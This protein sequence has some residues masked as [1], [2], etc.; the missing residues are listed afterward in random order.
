MRKNPYVIVIGI[1]GLVIL[2]VMALFKIIT[3]RQVAATGAGL[4]F[5]LM[6]LGVVFF[7]NRHKVPT[8]LLWYFFL[9]QFW[10]LFAVPIFL[11]RIMNWGVSFDQLSILGIPGPV[12]HQWS[13]KSY[14]MM[15]VGTC[16]QAWRWGKDLKNT[17]KPE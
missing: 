15:M 12:L 17:K 7:L 14:I 10:G 4:L 16:L 11:L 1:Q 5:V 6:P 13:S 3:D 2:M 9:V 8:G